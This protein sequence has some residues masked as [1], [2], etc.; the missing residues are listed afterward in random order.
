MVKEQPCLVFAIYVA[1]NA[2][3]L[4]VLAREQSHPRRDTDRGGHVGIGEKS[5][6]FREAVDIRS[7][8]FGLSKLRQIGITEAVPENGARGVVMM[9]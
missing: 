5:A 4:L 8:D 6:F 7:G 3:P 1:I 9:W 2:K